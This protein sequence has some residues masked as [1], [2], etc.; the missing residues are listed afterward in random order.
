MQDLSHKARALFAGF[1]WTPITIKTYETEF[2]LF[3]LLQGVYLTIF[4]CMRLESS[5]RASLFPVLS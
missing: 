3:W 2:G 5:C 1:C 4:A